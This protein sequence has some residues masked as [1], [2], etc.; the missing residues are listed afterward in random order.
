MTATT[1][2]IL[3][4]DGTGRGHA[5]CDLFVRTNPT[6]TVYYGPG[7]DVIEHERIVPVPSVSLLDPSTALAFLA[8]HPVEFAFVG[9]IDALSIGYADALREAGYPVIGPGG[10]AARLE[11]S[12]AEGKRFCVAHGIPV[13][14]FGVFDDP[15]AA[16]AY[17]RAARYA[18]VVKVD[19]LTPDGDGSLV[20]DTAVEAEAAVDR[21]VRERGA[22]SLVIEERVSG[23]EISV[24]ALVDG[25]SALMLP[26]ARDYKRAL[27]GDTG[28]NCDGMGSVAPHPLDGPH[29]RARLGREL[30]DPLVRG[31]R[32]ENLEFTGFVY[33]GVVLTVRGPV[34]LEINA[35]FGDS[36]AEVVLPSVRSDFTRL[37]RAVL[38]GRLDRERLETDGL[39]RCSVALTQG[40]LDPD[41]PA[42]LP[43]W[44]FGPFAAGQTVRGLHTVDPR[45]ATVFYANLRRDGAGL[46]VTTGGRVLH[47]VGAGSTAGEARVRAYRQAAR[48]S[49]PG[50]RLRADI[51]RA[52]APALP[53][54]VMEASAMEPDTVDADTVSSGR[55]RP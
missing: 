39:A 17:I 51:G 2:A 7:C 43:G 55:S 26:S 46:P 48:I 42:A 19:G 24:L 12:K 9:N 15:A 5:L 23:P 36:E 47:V 27:E 53:S 33:L 3:V 11:A 25:N 52:S 28:K 41:D 4:V 50:K 29:L 49:F 14:E 16:K 34:V 22:R 40:C 30:V 44:P 6:V 38:A 21:L 45:E 35:R 8:E 32:R 13:P 31:L 20:C 18:C 54:A 10:A 37:C 1:P